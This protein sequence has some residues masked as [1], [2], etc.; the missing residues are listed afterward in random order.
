VTGLTFVDTGTRFS[1]FG[2]AVVLAL[3]QVG[4]SAS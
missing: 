2:Q 3:I 1:P 4:G